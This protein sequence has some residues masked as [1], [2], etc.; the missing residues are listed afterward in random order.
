MR[1]ES[2]GELDL[3]ETVYEKR[4]RIAFVTLNRQHAGNSFNVQMCDE[5][6]AIWT[7]FRDEDDVWVAV[8]S[9]A[10]TRFFCTGVDVKESRTRP[11]GHVWLRSRGSWRGSTS[12]SSAP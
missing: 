1:I 11:M 12:P 2:I 10:G 3:V 8:L 4:D 6:E 5:M 7:D 9:A